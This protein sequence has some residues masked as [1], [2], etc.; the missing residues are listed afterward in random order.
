V[1]FILSNFE[2][3]IWT[4]VI[5]I[6]YGVFGVLYFLT[7]HIDH[8]QNYKLKK[9]LLLVFLCGPLTWIVY[10]IGLLID[11]LF[12]SFNNIFHK[13]FCEWLKK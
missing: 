4:F 11:I 7:S 3:F 13:P 9:V 1:D 5:S 12:L 8:T 10:P 2:V 6:T